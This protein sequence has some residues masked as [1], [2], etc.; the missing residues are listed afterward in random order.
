MER[1]AENLS[2]SDEELIRRLFQ[3]TYALAENPEDADD[4]A[5][6]LEEACQRWAPERFKRQAWSE[7]ADECADDPA[8]RVREMDALLERVEV[9]AALR[10]LAQELGGT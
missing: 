10:P 4:L 9:R 3:E 1:D 7:L 8:G 2:L 6:L 5:A